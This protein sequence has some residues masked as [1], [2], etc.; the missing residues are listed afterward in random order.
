MKLQ[1]I[2]LKKNFK[3]D[4]KGF[5]LLEILLVVAAIAILAGIIILA[6]N[7][8]KQLGDTRNS[9]RRLAIDSIVNAIYQYS[10]DH[11]GALP[12]ATSDAPIP[13]GTDISY[14]KEI[15]LNNPKDP[16]GGLIMECSDQNGNYVDLSDL[17]KNSLYLTSIPA[18]P[19]PSAT[20]SGMAEN[21]NQFWPCFKT[22]TTP[23]DPMNGLGSYG[24]PGPDSTDYLPLPTPDNT[25]DGARRG[26][27]YFIYQ[28]SNTHLIHVVA[29]CAEQTNWN[30]ADGVGA[31]DLSTVR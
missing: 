27:A 9:Q 24:A 8:N 11:N 1:N 18:D 2:L 23:P 10:L 17:T 21:G 16:G 26:S 7:P 6:I 4:N 3:K 25:G 19:L 15:C 22:G 31:I 12:G 14:A 5:T 30:D 20:D 29:E 13:T 28:D